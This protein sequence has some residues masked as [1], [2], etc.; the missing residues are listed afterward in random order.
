MTA[1]TLLEAAALVGAIV[2]GVLARKRRNQLEETNQKLRMINQEL[3]RQRQAATPDDMGVY[4]TA[5]ERSLGAPSAAHPVETY[6]NLKVSLARA[7]RQIEETIRE[8]KT[9]LHNSSS[10]ASQSGAAA[11][12]LLADALVVCKDIK[13]LRAERA[14]VRLRARALRATGDLEGS[15]DE[16]QRV[17]DL[18]K[19]VDDKPE[20]DADT[21]GE[22]GDVMAEMGNFEKAGKYYDL[23]ISAIQGTSNGAEG[24][25][26]WDA[27]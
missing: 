1:L 19:A 9:L 27:A 22:M 4:R 24:I 12:P 20:E 15:F 6:G 14:V 10:P 25:S 13:D 8:A 11:L 21:L 17:L 26:T 16:L 2:G 7:R 5:L 18:S 3:R 23:T